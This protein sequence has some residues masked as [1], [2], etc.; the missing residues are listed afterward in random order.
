MVYTAVDNHEHV[1]LTA[2]DRATGSVATWRRI[3]K[4][5]ASVEN[6]IK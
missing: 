1:L 4:D 6:M 5:F 3:T 2:A